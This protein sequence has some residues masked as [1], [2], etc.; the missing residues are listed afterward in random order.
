MISLYAF[1]KGRLFRIQVRVENMVFG[2]TGP[3][4][5]EFTPDLRNTLSVEVQAP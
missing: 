2:S 4:D 3:R 1:L 5:L